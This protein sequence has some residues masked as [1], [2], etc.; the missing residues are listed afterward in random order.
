MLP[1]GWRVCLMVSSGEIVAS[2]F[3][4]R[5]VRID[6]SAVTGVRR[7]W[8]KLLEHDEDGRIRAKFNS[9]RWG[10]AADRFRGALEDSVSR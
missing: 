8:K 10:A 7:R 9:N 5:T 6:R 3:V 4:R 1:L 2:G